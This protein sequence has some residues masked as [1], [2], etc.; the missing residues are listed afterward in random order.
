MNVSRQNIFILA[1]MATV[2]TFSSVSASKPAATENNVEAT[3]APASDKVRDD[4]TKQF[5]TL[6]DAAF[7]A[8][9]ASF[10]KRFLVNELLREGVKIGLGVCLGVWL[11]LSNESSASCMDSNNLNALPIEAALAALPILSDRYIAT[12]DHFLSALQTL[13]KQVRTLTPEQKKQCLSLFVEGGY[14]DKLREKILQEQDD[15]FVSIQRFGRLLIDFLAI[16]VIC[17]VV[18]NIHNKDVCGRRLL[19]ASLALITDVPQI[20]SNAFKDTAAQKRDILRNIK[21]ALQ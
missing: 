14:M 11:H 18:S 9:N 10:I 20:L 6:L 2:G 17:A 7:D 1:L 3:V 4:Q 8:Q 12:S 15:A 5:D 16:A 13:E 21:A 19:I